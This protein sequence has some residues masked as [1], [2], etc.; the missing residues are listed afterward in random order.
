[1]TTNYTSTFIAASPDSVAALGAAPKAGTVAAFVLALMNERPYG[2]TSDDLLFE[3]HAHRVRLADTDRVQERELF[4]AKPRA[5]LRAS[6]LVKQH[7]WGLHHDDCSRVA[8]YGV[9]TDDYRRHATDPKLHQ[10]RGMRS[11]RA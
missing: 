2:Y 8:A 10:T 7:G 1:M 9:E 6:A 5:C 4:L 3:A 11:K